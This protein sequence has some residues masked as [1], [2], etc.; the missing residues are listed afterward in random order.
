[1]KFVSLRLCVCHVPLAGGAAAQQGGKAITKD[2]HQPRNGNAGRRLPALWQRICRNHERRRSR[3]VDRAAHTKGSNE[4]IPLLEKGQLDIALVA[5]EPAYEA[6]RGSGGRAAR[7]KSSP[8]SI[9][10]PA[11]S[12]CAPT[13][14]TRHSDLV[15]HPV[16]FGAKGSGLP[17]CRVTCSMASA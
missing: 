15:G 6:F 2:A 9:P 16:A 12:W 17:S 1:M 5:G 11:C 14:P 8:P 10:T 4:N 13:A 7:R 3:A